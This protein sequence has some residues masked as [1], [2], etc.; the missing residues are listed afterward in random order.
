VVTGQVGN[1]PGRGRIAPS[2]DI[3]DI[4]QGDVIEFRPTDPARL[5]DTEQSRLVQFALGILRQAAK[6]LASGGALAQHRNERFG[7]L[8]HGG[9]VRAHIGPG[10]AGGMRNGLGHGYL[11]SAASVDC[12]AGLKS[13]LSK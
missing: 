2:E 11:R 13:G 8:H 10:P 6:L 1:V 4:D 3:G 12:E 5:E 7:A 9:I